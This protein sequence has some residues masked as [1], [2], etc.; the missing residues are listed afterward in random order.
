ML[1]LWWWLDR[2]V[3]ICLQ[4][5]TSGLCRS[6]VVHLHR[7]RKNV[8][9]FLPQWR[10]CKVTA[11][12]WP[13]CMSWHDQWTGSLVKDVEQRFLFCI[14]SSCYLLSRTEGSALPVFHRK[15]LPW[16]T[17]DTRRVMQQTGT[18]GALTVWWGE[19]RLTLN[20]SHCCSTYCLIVM[21]DPFFCITLCCRDCQL[22]TFNSYLLYVKEAVLQHLVFLI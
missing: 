3:M 1:N 17:P 11:V 2:P 16:T 15:R 20:V 6:V 10:T 4:P 9:N 8:N 19:C 22:K 18:T 7:V 14:L 5:H 13:V 21:T 12:L